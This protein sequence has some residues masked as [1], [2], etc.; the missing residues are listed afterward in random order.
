[1]GNVI[2]YTSPMDAMGFSARFFVGKNLGHF[3][4]KLIV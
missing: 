1:M 3:S 2:K 4:V